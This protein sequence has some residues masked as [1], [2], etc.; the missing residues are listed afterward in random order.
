MVQAKPL[1]INYI[2]GVGGRTN[3]TIIG[4]RPPEIAIH[5]FLLDSQG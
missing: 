2:M 4:Y 1:N 3:D 5:K